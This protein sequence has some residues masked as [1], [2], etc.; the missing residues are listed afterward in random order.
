M[1]HKEAMTP[2]WKGF[3]RE[4][5]SERDWPE[6]LRIEVIHHPEVEEH[7]HELMEQDY[8]IIQIF[9]HWG[10][11]EV[12][13]V[14]KFN[15]QNPDLRNARLL[16][17]FA[18]HQY[19]TKYALFGWPLATTLNR[20]STP[21][22]NEIFTGDPRKTPPQ[23]EELNKNFTRNAA[24]MLNHGGVVLF[25]PELERNDELPD[26]LPPAFPAFLG[27][28]QQEGVN[29]DKTAILTIGTGLE[30]VDN[31]NTWRNVKWSDPHPPVIV[32][33]ASIV[34]FSKTGLAGRL[35]TSAQW[36]RNQMAM[37]DPN[38]YIAQKGFY[39]I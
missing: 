22:S 13:A 31:Y 36:A 38:L 19:K 39:Q 7:L 8:G 9:R 4:R 33:P 12:P 3:L 28:I 5:I 29:L 35:R 1:V 34:P 14:M 11:M 18:V 6:G 26:K 20:T 25:A 15:Y 27:G 30:G 21:H 10:K 32:N 37:A 24:E 17:P 23:H 2:G 16:A